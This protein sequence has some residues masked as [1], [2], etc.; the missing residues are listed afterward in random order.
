MENKS[1]HHG[2]LRGSLIEMGLE[3]ISQEGEGMLSLRKVAEKCGVSNAAPYAHFGSKNEFIGAIQQHILDLFTAALEGAANKYRNSSSLLPKIGKAYVMFFY[4]NPLYYDFLFSRKN[5]EIKLSLS[6]EKE[7]KNKPL[8][9]LKQTAMQMF[10]KIGM[11]EK[12]MQDKIIAMW[13]L[14]HGLSAIA[15]MPNVEYDDN[16][17]MRIE[18]IIKS[19]SI[20]YFTEQ[21][22]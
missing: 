8:E 4:Q 22:E 3:I 20:P 10:S 2:N 18:S 21:G 1:Y 11:P 7:S 5:I 12:V 9:I 17:E 13:A 14:V 6:N 16:W 15:A 19:V